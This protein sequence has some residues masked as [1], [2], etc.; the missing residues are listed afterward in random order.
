MEGF[1]KAIDEVLDIADDVQSHG[2]LK[3]REAIKRAV[4]IGDRIV[5]RSQPEY[6]DVQRKMKLLSLLV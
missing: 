1:N 2:Y 5:P 4:A 6:R 3:Y